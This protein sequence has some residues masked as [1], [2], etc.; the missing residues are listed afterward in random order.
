M[1]VYERTLEGGLVAVAEVPIGP[2]RRPVRLDLGPWSGPDFDPAG[3]RGSPVVVVAG[4]GGTELARR[5]A[6]RSGGQPT[7]LILPGDAPRLGIQLLVAHQE[8]VD[9]T[10]VEGGSGSVLNVARYLG[11]RPIPALPLA[12]P[13]DVGHMLEGC[14]VD[15]DVPVPSLDGEARERIA[16]L[17]APLALH[18]LHHV[19]E[20]DPRPAFDDLGLPIEGAAPD[21]LTAAAAGVLAGRVSVR[22]RRWRQA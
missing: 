9:V 15:L 4:P 12:A 21:A 13:D 11:G 1:I 2:S 18:E 5:G 20:V 8:G 7:V 3:L 16:A 10:I 17:M 22:S 14:E 6:L 19:V